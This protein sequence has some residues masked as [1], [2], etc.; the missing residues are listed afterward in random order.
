MPLHKTVKYYVF[1]IN[2]NN[3]LLSKQELVATTLQDALEEYKM[4]PISDNFKD[5]S[6]LWAHVEP[7]TKGAK[8]FWEE[9]I[10]FSKTMTEVALK[11]ADRL[12]TAKH[13]NYFNT[14]GSA[15][16]SAKLEETANKTRR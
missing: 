8:P 5:N 13:K 16:R 2:K 3:I 14:L 6:R 1:L 12:A 11:D 10:H 15:S 4:L 9:V 7:I